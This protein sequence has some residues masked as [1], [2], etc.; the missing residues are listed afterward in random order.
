MTI[1]VEEEERMWK[2]LAARKID[3]NKVP[4]GMERRDGWFKG[5]IRG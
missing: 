4:K 1:E 3:S 5:G 2:N